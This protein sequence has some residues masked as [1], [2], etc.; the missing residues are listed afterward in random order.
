MNRPD[1]PNRNTEAVEPPYPMAGTHADDQAERPP[2][3]PPEDFP[4][5]TGLGGHVHPDGPP[6]DQLSSDPETNIIPTDS[7]GG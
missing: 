6:S 1:E 4:R 7:P 5:G 3:P 2:T